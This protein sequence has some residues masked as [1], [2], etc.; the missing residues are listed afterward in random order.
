[1]LAKN[2]NA[3]SIADPSALV[4]ALMGTE[5][6]APELKTAIAFRL[7]TASMLQDVFDGLARAVLQLQGKQGAVDV[8]AALKF[9]LLAVSRQAA[10]VSKGFGGGTPGAA[11]SPGH[12][13]KR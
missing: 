9:A 6:I 13:V 10:P 8:S 2:R 3:C 5:G 7:S 11:S 12:K 1:M 4:Q